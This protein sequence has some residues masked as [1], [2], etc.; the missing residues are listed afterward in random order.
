MEANLRASCGE[1]KSQ[2]LD[3]R[4]MEAKISALPASGSRVTGSPGLPANKKAPSTRD[5]SAE[6][7][8]ALGKRGWAGHCLQ[9]PGLTP[10]LT[11]RQMRPASGARDIP[12]PLP[13]PHFVGRLSAYCLPSSGGRVVR[14]V[15]IRCS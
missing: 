15:D 13:L 9:P 4:E 1:R 6:A 3:I 2:G 10:S 12:V 14:A 8:A 7:W 5:P 11:H